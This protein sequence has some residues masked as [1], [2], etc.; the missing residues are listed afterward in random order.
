MTT[1]Q[2]IQ[3][4]ALRVLDEHKVAALRVLDEHQTDAQNVVF[5]LQPHPNRIQTYLEEATQIRWNFM[6]RQRSRLFL[7][8][9]SDE[10]PQY[11]EV[12]STSG[13]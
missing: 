10:M 12:Y 7:L 13:R 5:R 8:A 4:N 1:L 9:K 11:V 3:A 6:L 2:T